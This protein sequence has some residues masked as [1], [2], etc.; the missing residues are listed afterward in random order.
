MIF[1][2]RSPEAAQDL[3]ESAQHDKVNRNISNF[4]TKFD[5]DFI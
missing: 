3:W 1:L 2:E 4:P 5:F